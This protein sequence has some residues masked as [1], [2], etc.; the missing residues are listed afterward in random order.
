MALI[1]QTQK[2]SYD[3]LVAPEDKEVLSNLSEMGDHLKALSIKV[4]EAEAIFE[5]AKKEYD[6]Y[7]SS[8]LPMVMYNAGVES[9]T[10]SSGGTLKMQRKFRCTANKNATDR[11][12][13]CEWL[14]KNGL[15]KLIKESATVDGAQLNK[16]KEAGIPY[17]EVDDIN[18]NSLKANLASLLGAKGGIAQIQLT[19]IP[20]CF[21]FQEVTEVSID[22]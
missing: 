5:E 6:Y 12:I 2:D 14:R 8:V 19:D 1:E 20:E 10:L 13:Q 21:H 9:I 17:V 11:A 18:T 4:R 22:L 3:Y 16:L 15:E 7:A